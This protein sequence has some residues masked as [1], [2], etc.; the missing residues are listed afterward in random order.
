M[1]YYVV[2][3]H[4]VDGGEEILSI[5]KSKERAEELKAAYS[6][7]LVSVSIEEVDDGKARVENL[8]C[9]SFVGNTVVDSYIVF[10]YEA[11]CVDAF[12]TGQ[13]MYIGKTGFGCHMLDVYIIA[14]SESEA[15]EKATEI[16]K[17][18][19]AKHY[20]NGYVS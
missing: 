1:I 4:F 15:I 13:V 11:G 6:S 5:T 2:K 9:I 19:K 14:K 18:E 16:A 8:W 20:A 12:T 7:R 10:E 3:R 17:K